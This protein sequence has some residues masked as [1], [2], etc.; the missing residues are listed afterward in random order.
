MSAL[1]GPASA[2]YTG[3]VRH[4]RFAVREQQ[5]THGIALAYLDLREL[6][7]LVSGR[8]LSRRPGLVRFRRED[9]LGDPAVPLDEEV[10]A[11]VARRTGT[12]PDGP[13]RLLTHLRSFGHCFNPVSF[14]Y[15]FDRDERLAALVAEVT[16]TPWGERRAYVVGHDGAGP[17]LHGGMAKDMHVSPFLGMDQ[18]YAWHAATPGPTA[19]VHIENHEDGR[20][21]FDATLS[22]RR[23]P[24]TRDALARATARYPA[25]TL[26]MLALIYAHAAVAWLRGIP[27]HPHPA[28]GTA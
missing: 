15:C 23:E 28:G 6:P 24:F 11:L 18:R 27:V 19:S 21:V 22:L 20:R 14:Y 25:A 7:H 26:R 10:R 4:R 1:A 5:F 16:S 12:A 3:T 17:V 2:I 9:Y 8:L 13:V